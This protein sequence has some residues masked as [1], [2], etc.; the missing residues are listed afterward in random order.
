MKPIDWNGRTNDAE[1]KA[2]AQAKEAE[3]NIS[4]NKKKEQSLRITCKIMKAS[5]TIPGMAH[6]KSLW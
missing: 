2:K 6:W 1:E 5:T 3:K 4:S